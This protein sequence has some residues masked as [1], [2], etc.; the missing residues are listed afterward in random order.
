MRDEQY[1][2][3]KGE[4]I[5][6]IEN[7]SRKRRRSPDNCDRQDGFERDNVPDRLPYWMWQLLKQKVDRPDDS[8][9]SVIRHIHQKPGLCWHSIKVALVTLVAAPIMIVEIGL[10]LRFLLNR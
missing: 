3:T 1:T 8:R 4:T 9:H 5:V 2:R 7:P 10:L 6:V